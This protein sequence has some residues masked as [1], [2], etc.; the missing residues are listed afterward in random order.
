ML[1]LFTGLFEKQQ[2]MKSRQDSTCEWER[3][4]IVDIYSQHPHSGA[5]GG[6]TRFSDAA[7][8]CVDT[9][10]SSRICATFLPGPPGADRR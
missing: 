7:S 8:S 3:P 2:N 9:R 4:E 5:A 1:F 10:Y 6:A